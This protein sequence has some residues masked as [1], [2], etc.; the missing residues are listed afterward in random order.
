[1]EVVGAGHPYVPE[2]LVLHDY[3]PVFLP[4]S[5]II[6]VYLISS[7]L[8]VSAVGIGSGE[9]IPYPFKLD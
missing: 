6:G 2:D 7:L 1:M 9:R 3:V 8:V 5:T 4:Q